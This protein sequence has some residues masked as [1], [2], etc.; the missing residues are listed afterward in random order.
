MGGFKAGLWGLMGVHAGLGVYA[1]F[2]GL[3]SADVSYQETSELLRVSGAEES[4]GLPEIVEP[5]ELEL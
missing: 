1:G 5:P 3:L 2:W 4:G